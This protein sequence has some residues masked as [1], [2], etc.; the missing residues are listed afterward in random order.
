M[1][2]IEN[3]RSCGPQKQI[4]PSGTLAMPGN[5]VARGR[6]DL[7]VQLTQP[8]ADLDR[9]A[10]VGGRHAVA[11]GL[12]LGQSVARDD[13]LLAVAGRERQL[14][15][16]QQRLGRRELADRAP[17]PPAAVGDSHAPAIQI[18]LR[19]RR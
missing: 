10:G 17:S 4:E 14:R 13:P 11:V 7:Q 12:K 2:P 8:G 5:P 6:V 16:P 9:G 1:P 15:Q 19:L 3:Q 18:G